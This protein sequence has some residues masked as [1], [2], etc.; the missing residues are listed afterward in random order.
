L[1]VP[2]IGLT[3]VGATELLGDLL[4]SPQ[5]GVA[6]ACF[7][8][9]LSAFVLVTLAKFANA[10]DTDVEAFVFVEAGRDDGMEIFGSCA[11]GIANAED[12]GDVFGN[13]DA[14]AVGAKEKEI[15]ADAVVEMVVGAAG[16]DAGA[17]DVC[18]NLGKV[19][20]DEEASVDDRGNL[21]LDMEDMGAVGKMGALFGGFPRV[22]AVGG[23]AAVALLEEANANVEENAD[24]DSAA[25]EKGM[26]A[27]CEPRGGR[28]VAALKEALVVNFGNDTDVVACEKRSGDANDDLAA[29]VD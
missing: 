17:E 13:D 14:D 20:V 21:A 22:L 8:R 3:A 6:P 24:E 7:A 26:L 23:K 1:G 2:K 29:A 27:D 25:K 12:G 4:V 10:V 16:V 18:G 15:D 5:A 9:S 28:L 11:A 19:D